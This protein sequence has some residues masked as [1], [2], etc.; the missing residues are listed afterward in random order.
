MR[1]NVMTTRNINNPR[2]RLKALRYNPSLEFIG[3]SPIST[4]RL[5]NLEAANKSL[6]ICHN[7]SPAL[8]GAILTRTS[9]LRNIPIQ[10]DG[11]GAYADPT[12]LRSEN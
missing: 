3:P 6:T 7:K 8:A 4:T 2:T 11:D 9:M 12:F 10:W 5:D 1:N